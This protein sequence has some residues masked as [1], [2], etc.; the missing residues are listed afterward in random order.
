MKITGS[1]EDKVLCKASFQREEFKCNILYLCPL[2]SHYRISDL[3]MGRLV[4]GDL[5]KG[6]VPP[7]ASAVLDL[8]EKHGIH[9][10]IYVVISV[11]TFASELTIFR[12]V[13]ACKTQV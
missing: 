13:T 7:I 10:L 12:D 5:S 3:N 11:L 2:L 6:F 1:V 8:L 4:R 9:T